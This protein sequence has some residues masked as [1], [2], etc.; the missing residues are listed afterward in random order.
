MVLSMVA[1]ENLLLHHMDVKTAF[2]HG[3]LKEELYMT[4]PEGFIVKGKEG[5]VC[6]LKKSL[7]GLK[8]APKKWYK[9]FDSF[10]LENGYDRCD[11]DHCCYYKRFDKSYLILLLYVDDMLIAGADASEMDKLKKQLSERFSTK[12]LGEAKQILG[13]RIEL[14]KATR[15]LYLSQA[16]YIQNVLGR[17]N[18]DD[19][20]PMSV[21][22]D[23]HFKLSKKES[24]SSKEKRAQMMKIPYVSAIGSIMYAMVCTRPDIAQ[25]VGVVSR[26]M[27]DLGKQHWEAVKWVLRYLKGTM[28]KA[29][30]IYGQNVELVGYVDA[31]LASNDLDGRRST[32]GY[33]F[34]YGGTAK[35][36][37][38]KLQKV[39]ALSTTEAEYVAVTEASKEMVWSHNF[40]GELGNEHNNGTIYSDSQSAIFLAKNSAFH[41]R[42]KHIELKYHYIH[43]LLEQ[44]LCNL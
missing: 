29:L 5:L 9:K 26:F 21:P 32:T 31:D 23:S 36:W 16:N 42:T 43:H 41:S 20:K 13:M 24:P 25:A 6:K 40:L 4:Q 3:D 38:S 15:K 44:R 11:A 35:S 12:D 28:D 22:L 14:E 37:N 34:T 17:F 8:Q 39:V 33:V 1:A 19:S 7:Y 30:C 27:G 2:L 18:M 10:M